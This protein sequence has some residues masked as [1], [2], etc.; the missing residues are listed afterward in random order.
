M[1][2]LLHIKDANIITH[3]TPKY[4]YIQNT[5][6]LLHIKDANSITYKTPR[7]YHIKDAECKW[8]Y[9]ETRNFCYLPILIE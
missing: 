7:Y 5:Q 3:K 9:L 6:I 2:I 8:I 4:Y 1:Q